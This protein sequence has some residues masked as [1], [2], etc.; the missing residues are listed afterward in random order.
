VSVPTLRVARRCGDPFALAAQYRDGLGLQELGR[1][2]GHAGHDGVMLGFPGGGWHLELVRTPEPR[3]APP[4]P[5]DALMLYC[6]EDAA[7]SRRCE[8][9]IAAGFV[10][11]AACN[12]Y[13]AV[14]GHCLA[15]GEGFGV[16]LARGQW[17]R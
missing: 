5:E 16:I 3:P 11:I 17:P 4:D 7:W 8:R 9:A 15:D 13:W 12:P 2:A 14:N 6:G 10:P 1:F